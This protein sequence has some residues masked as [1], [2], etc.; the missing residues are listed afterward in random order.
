VTPADA[1]RL[2]DPRLTLQQPGA[3][4]LL[5][6][7]AGLLTIAPLIFLISPNNLRPELWRRWATWLVIALAAALPITLGA[8]AT[9]LALLVLA[10]ACYREFGR[11][12]GLF[13]HRLT[14]VAVVVGIVLTFAAAVDNYY[15]LFVALFPLSIALIALAGILP[16]RPNGYLQRTALGVF[17]Y[18]LFGSGLGHLAFFTNEPH[19]RALLLWLVLAVALNDVFAFTAGKLLGRRRLAPNTS[20]SKTWGGAL[21]AITLTMV[22]S[23]GLGWFVFDGRVYGWWP[24]VLVL[25]LT[26]GVLGQFGDLLLSS[27]KRDLGLEDFGQLLPGHGGLLD[28]IDSL[29][30]VTPAV[31]HYVGYLQGVGDGATERVFSAGWF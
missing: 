31:F 14:S 11:A 3:L 21:G 4:W 26:V 1:T 22:M 8:A 25:A 6:L 16:D 29:I 13:R 17:A 12:T 5:G 10:L 28:R 7:V 30:L 2:F 15:A 23:G 9:C 27:I 18:A 19:Y 20:P 24:H